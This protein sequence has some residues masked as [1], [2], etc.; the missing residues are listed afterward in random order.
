MRT[1]IDKSKIIILKKYFEKI[2]KNSFGNSPV[3]QTLY[4]LRNSLSQNI[5]SDNIVNKAIP[6]IFGPEST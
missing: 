6:R 1:M 5:A 2:F 3:Y 4:I